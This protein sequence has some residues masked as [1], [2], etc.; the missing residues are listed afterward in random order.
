MVFRDETPEAGILRIMPVISHHPVIIQTE[1]IGIGRRAI[2]Q[3]FPI[4]NL[5][6]ITFID[7]NDPPVGCNVLRR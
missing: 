3:E 5:Q 2:D 7:L 4:L 1:G 6:L